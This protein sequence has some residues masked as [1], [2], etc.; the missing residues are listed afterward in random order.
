MQFESSLYKSADLNP[1]ILGQLI[2]DYREGDVYGY[3]LIDN[4]LVPKSFLMRLYECLC[5]ITFDYGDIWSVEE[6]L[7]NEFWSSLN[8]LERSVA[9]ACVLI[10][11]EN[12][13]AIAMPDEFI[14]TH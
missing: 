7:G 2:D 3:F 11:F 1:R 9:G 5:D 10:I 13:Y 8:D 14:Q 12:G 6:L 4:K